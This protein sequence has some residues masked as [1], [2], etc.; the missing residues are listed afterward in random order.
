MAGAHGVERA[1]AIVGILTS[2]L[3]MT[4]FGRHVRTF[5]SPP[6]AHAAHG[7]DWMDVWAAGVLFAEAVEKWRLTRSHLAP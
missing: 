7:V 3:L 6:T 5:A 2:A 1:L 4:A